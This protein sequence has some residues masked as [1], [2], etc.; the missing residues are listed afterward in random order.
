MITG[1]TARMAVQDAKE[2]TYEYMLDG[3]EKI[4]YE[5]MKLLNRTDILSTETLE[6]IHNIIKETLELIEKEPLTKQMI[7]Q[8]ENK[9]KNTMDPIIQMLASSN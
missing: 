5:Y 3:I 6:T 1:Y 2:S 8:Q 7:V 4:S 9:I